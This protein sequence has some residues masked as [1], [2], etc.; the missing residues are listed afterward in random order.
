MFNKK[1]KR[2]GIS[3]K[4]IQAFLIVGVI[5]VS[6]VVL[7]STFSFSGSFRNLAKTSEKQIEL[8]KTAREL[9][10]A[11]D[12]LTENVQR[13][14]VHGETRFM[15]NYFKE[16]LDSKR[17][18]EAV[19]KMARESSDNTALTGLLGAL[20]DSVHL[21]EREYYAMRLVAEAQGITDYP[22]AIAETELSEADRAKSPDEKMKLAS[23]MVHD[24]AYYA[25]KDRIR[26]GMLTSLDALENMAYSTDESAIDSLHGEMVFVRVIVIVAMLG[27]F[28]M[29]WLTSRLGIHPVLNAVDRIR[30]DNTIPETG[31][32]EFRY[33]A[34]AYNK[35]YGAYRASLE[36]LNFKASHDE[37]TGAYNRSG[38]DLL[39]SSMDL[40]STCMLLFD[41]DDFKSVNDSRGHKTGDN[42]LIKLTDVLRNSFRADDYICRIGGDEFVVFMT[43]AT[44]LQNKLISAKIAG[45]N[46]EMGA[47]DADCPAVSV[48]VGIAHGSCASDPDDLFE[49]ADSAMYESKQKGKKAFT[50]YKENA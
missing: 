29:V 3:L 38:Y 13:F 33:L 12:Y 14:T 28:V 7:I 37:L 30:A 20:S 11:S 6:G 4:T 9:M 41:V 48:S 22:E 24:D 36:R 21:M 45:I 18:E 32:N 43:H 35:M 5:L 34:R 26:A 40:G 10:D 27:T 23:E 2:E 17:R 46:K 15:D 19:K 44:T 8:R 47:A 49:K 25:E 39:L 16:A 1:S 50:F 31:A 42:V